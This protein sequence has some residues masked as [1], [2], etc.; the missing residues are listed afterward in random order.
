MI[1]IVGVKGNFT[2]KSSMVA[3]TIQMYSA[4]VLLHIS[5][6]NNKHKNIQNIQKY[7]RI[8]SM[9]T[10]VTQALVRPNIETRDFQH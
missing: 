8:N 6:S 3:T 10:K 7:Y 1:A 4:Q 9:K 2:N 5:L